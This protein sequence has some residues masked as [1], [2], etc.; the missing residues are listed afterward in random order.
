MAEM[1]KV[2]FQFPD[3]EEVKKPAEADASDIEIEIEDDTPEDDRG[4]SPSDPTKVKQLEIEVSDLDKYSKE[5]KDKLIRMKRV[6]NDERRA[7]EQAERERQAAVEALQT[8]YG[9]YSQTREIL[10]KG[11]EQYKDAVK[12]AAKAELREAKN[13]YKQAYEAGD[14]AA[15]AEAQEA[16]VK[17]Q[18]NLEDI[19]KFKLPTLQQEKPVVEQQPQPV[20][21]PSVPKPDERA[22]RW[23]DDNPWFGQDKGM[24]AYALGVH[25]ELR[26]DGVPI[27]SEDYYAALDKT[28]RKRFPE[29][30]AD[31][32]GEEHEVERRVKADPPKT[33]PSTVVA[34]ATRTT[35]PKRVRLTQSQVAIAKKLNLTPEQYVRELLKLEA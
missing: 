3:E 4:R 23:Q 26:D 30:F 5:A 18:L 8:L 10:Y 9:Q 35:A 1:E 16:M 13:A 11:E 12:A 32:N 25:D 29:K 6:W 34:P 7:K 28:L 24:T 19:K 22:M 20:R 31:A 17:A 21:Q 33:K 27:G 14:S 15:M 2:E